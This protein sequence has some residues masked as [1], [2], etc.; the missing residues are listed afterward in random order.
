MPIAPGKAA[1]TL[2]ERLLETI[3]TLPDEAVGET[4]EFIHL[5]NLAKPL[6]GRQMGFVGVLRAFEI[7]GFRCG[8]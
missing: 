6:F 8:L 7:P 1:M 2:K 3:A 5:F 4:L